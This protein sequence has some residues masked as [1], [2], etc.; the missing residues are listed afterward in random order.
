MRQ[1]NVS[2][3]GDWTKAYLVVGRATVKPSK[4]K[5]RVVEGR[6]NMATRQDG[7]RDGCQNL[8]EILLSS[9]KF[10]GGT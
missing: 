7:A 6:S 5:K 1:R 2:E 3:V 8:R 10:E 4:A 9:G